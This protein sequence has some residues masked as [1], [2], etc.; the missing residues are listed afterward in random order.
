MLRVYNCPSVLLALLLQ[1]TGLG[2]II[3][4]GRPI[5]WTSQSYP[6]FQQTWGITYNWS[7]L[8]SC[9]SKQLL[10]WQVV[11]DSLRNWHAKRETETMEEVKEIWDPERQ[12]TRQARSPAP[13]CETLPI[14]SSHTDLFLSD[15]IISM[16]STGEWKLPFTHINMA[17]IVNYLQGLFFSLCLPFAYFSCENVVLM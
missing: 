13:G 14:F 11:F 7:V 2:I 1:D 10:S 3:A 15:R 17:R 6:P 8:I 12:S 9:Q 5:T 16:H 4:S